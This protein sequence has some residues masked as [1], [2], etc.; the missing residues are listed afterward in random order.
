MKLRRKF[1]WVEIMDDK[2][3]LAEELAQK[4]GMHPMTLRRYLR[5]YTNIGVL[6]CHKIGRY[7]Y[8]A[9]RK[10]YEEWKRKR[11]EAQPTRVVERSINEKEVES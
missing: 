8:Y 2:A 4:L 11:S 5:I 7:K 1:N 10:R 9:V 6:I 3:W